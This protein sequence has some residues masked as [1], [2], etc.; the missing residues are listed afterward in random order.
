MLLLVVAENDLRTK[1]ARPSNN[2]DRIGATI[3]QIADEDKAIFILRVLH[4][5]EKLVQLLKTTMYVAY[6]NRSQILY[7]FVLSLAD[8]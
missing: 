2:P 1:L 4:Y 6:Y 7:S 5:R 8:G 3:H